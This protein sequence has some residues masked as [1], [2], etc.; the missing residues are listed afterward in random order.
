[1]SYT[2]IVNKW[3]REVNNYDN[4][5]WF[6][7]N[8]HENIRKAIKQFDKNINDIVLP[9]IEPVNNIIKSYLSISD[10][11]DE[12]VNVPSYKIFSNL[13][14]LCFYKSYLSLHCI[15]SYNCYS[16]ALV[17]VIDTLDKNNTDIEL[18]H[19][20]KNYQI[21]DIY[22]NKH[23]VSMNVYNNK[24]LHMSLDSNFKGIIVITMNPYHKVTLK[25]WT[26]APRI[27]LTLRCF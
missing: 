21:L 14:L 13:D 24:T 10:Y 4:Y 17:M 6:D 8:Q 20:F 23:H 22:A 9:L 15:G 2:T 26:N 3:L 5:Y 12:G 11:Y 16:P 7:R 25:F 18:G 27:V 19:M 1:M